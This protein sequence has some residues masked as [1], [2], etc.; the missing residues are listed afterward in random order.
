M[1]RF[2][3]FK[4][5]LKYAHWQY[6]KII[7]DGTWVKNVFVWSYACYKVMYINYDKYITVFMCN[8]W[9]KYYSTFLIFSMRLSNNRSKVSLPKK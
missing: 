5:F 7:L 4:Y 8:V 3:L 6:V 1:Y 9:Y 2:G